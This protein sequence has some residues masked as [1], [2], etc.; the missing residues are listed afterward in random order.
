MHG[1]RGGVVVVVSVMFEVRLRLGTVDPNI[2]SHQPSF[3]Y[4]YD[5]HLFTLILLETSENQPYFGF[6]MP[7]YASGIGVRVCRNA[8][9]LHS[10]IFRRFFACNWS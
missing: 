5:P 1:D 10:E 3:G 6:G 9:H 7:T 2:I 8:L 4:S